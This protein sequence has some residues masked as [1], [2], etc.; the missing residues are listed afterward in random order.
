MASNSTMLGLP[1]TLVVAVY[2]TC[3]LAICV[4]IIPLATGQSIDV[5]GVLISP[6]VQYIYGSWLCIMIIATIAAAI[7]FYYH[8]ESHLKIYL[9]LVAMSAVLDLSW[10][11]IF[12]VF[13]ASCKSTWVNEVLTTDCSGF[14]SWGLLFLCVVFFF[15]H[16]LGI[17]VTV[18]AAAYARLHF[19]MD[20]LPYL[21]ST[22]PVPK[23]HWVE[24]EPDMEQVK[25]STPVPV[26][27]ASVIPTMTKPV[28]APPVL[29]GPPPAAP[30]TYG[31]MV[32]RSAPVVTSVPAVSSSLPR[33]V[34]VV[35]AAPNPFQSM[36]M[37]MSAPRA[38]KPL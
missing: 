32:S 3:Q 25:L 30:R 5:G 15:F 37:P 20:L 28:L 34:P 22:L 38:Y 33:S 8:I 17:W 12:V 35:S 16:V 18:K 9:P 26:S 27:Q 24:E 10:L 2:C 4:S 13:G 14:V 21:T 19:S 7:G 31:T 29:A 1:L 6:V 36:S 11:V 23:N